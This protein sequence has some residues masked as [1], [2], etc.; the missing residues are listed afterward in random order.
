MTERRIISFA[1]V[2][3]LAVAAFSACSNDANP[4]LIFAAASLV[5]VM[6][7]V[8]K[9]YEAD[10]GESV[11][12]NFGG[13]NLLAN[14]IITGAKADAIIVAGKTPIN[15][16]VNDGKINDPNAI[17]I[18]TN[19]L[20]AVRPS[21][22]KSTHTTLRELI[23]TGRIAIPDPQ[24]APAG[25]YIEA[26]LREMG[27]WIGLEPQLIPTLDVRAALAA[28]SSKNVAYAFVYETD[29]IS[30]D[31][32]EVAF[33]IDSDSEASTPRYYA[34]ALDDDAKTKRFIDYLS[35][36]PAITIFKKHGFTP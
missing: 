36:P 28:V 4:P 12:F 23:G 35:S 16:L 18:F 17:E 15:K 19:R 14:Q 24:T 33:T 20:V 1:A 11:R 10:T 5:D 32:V 6:D 8:A 31:D 34:A 22:S 26:A 30:T 2:L 13:S 9:Q 3:I 25:E 27:L 29:A 7:D 21:G